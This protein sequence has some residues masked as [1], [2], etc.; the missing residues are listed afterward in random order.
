MSERAPRGRRH[1]RSLRTRLSLLIGAA[2]VL[3][4]G[5]AAVFQAES[6]RRQVLE[7]TESD[8]IRLAALVARA[9]LISQRAPEVLDQ[10]IGDQMVATARVAA[11]LVAIGKAAG[12]SDAAITDS[13]AAVAE[14]SVAREFWITDPTGRAVIHNVPGVDFTFS[15]DRAEQPQ[16]YVFYPLL[17]ESPDGAPV[18]QEARVREIDD[19]VWKYA[20]VPGTDGPRIVQVGVPAD[21]LT[22]LRAEVDTER[23]ATTL[24]ASDDDVQTVEV[25]DAAGR[26]DA[27]SRIAGARPPDRTTVERLSDAARESGRV[28]TTTAGSSLLA[29]APVTVDGRDLGVVL[30][31][32]SLAEAEA[33]ARAVV[34]RGVLVGLLALAVGIVLA[35]FGARRIVRPVEILTGAAA[36]LAADDF[37]PAVLDPVCARTDEL[38]E[39]ARAFRTMGSEV[40]ERERRLRA[41]VASLTVEID[42]GRVARDVGEIVDTDFFR[43]LQ[44][45][46]AEMRRRDR[47]R[48][49]EP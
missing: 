26:L 3:A 2:L 10:A 17:S 47:D 18:I 32:I 30:V 41:R 37:D 31:G 36:D 38:G 24:T 4:V 29:V 23:F 33:A 6:A 42:R 40:V 46:A 8:A 19:Q 28:E 34:W 35:F 43:D 14:T 21:V 13:L 25:Y 1:A 16:A 45:R 22:R 12:L 27:S 48:S 9:S 39:L 20:G 5:V 7:Q 49:P 11:R 44:A 15:P